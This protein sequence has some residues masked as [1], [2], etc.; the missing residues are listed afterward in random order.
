MS[1][2]LL[3]AMV[4]TAVLICPSLIRAANL[5]VDG[6]GGGTTMN[7]GVGTQGFY[8]GSAGVRFHENFRVFGEMGFS[9]LGSLSATANS[10][11]TTYAATIGA[12][13]LS[14][15]G[16]LDYSFR[17][18]EKVDPYLLVAVGGAHI[19]GTVS[20]AT[21]SGFS[22]SI[23]T[24][25]GN[26]VYAGFGGGVRFFIGRKWGIKAE[27]RFQRY[28]SSELGTLSAGYYTAGLFYQFGER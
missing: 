28:G 14:F 16:G 1:I 23:S 5:E 4:F 2:R 3:N 11:G 7:G 15:G 24:G 25:V 21:S 12:N 27:G 10:G 26:M 22:G 6:G 8:G 18:S 20:A 19:T 9:Q 13:L 17:P